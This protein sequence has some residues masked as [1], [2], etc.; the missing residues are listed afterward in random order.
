VLADEKGRKVDARL[1]EAAKEA[2]NKALPVHIEPNRYC[3]AK[4]HSKTKLILGFFLNRPVA[5]LWAA[6]RKGDIRES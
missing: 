5:H 4:I 3:F 6:S 1:K 2:M